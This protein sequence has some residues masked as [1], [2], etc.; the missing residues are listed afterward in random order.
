MNLEDETGMVNVLCSTG[1]WARHRWLAQT[2]SALLIRGQVQNASGAVTVLAEKRAGGR[3]PLRGGDRDMLIALP[4]SDRRY[5]LKLDDD[6]VDSVG[7]LMAK[8]LTMVPIA[9]SVSVVTS[10]PKRERARAPSVRSR[11]YGIFCSWCRSFC[12]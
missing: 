11:R 7:G 4:A 2:A 5:R 8:G 12:G 9:G 6:D 3:R 1:V 10:T